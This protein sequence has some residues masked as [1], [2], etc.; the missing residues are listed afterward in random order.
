MSTVYK[1]PIV[2]VSDLDIE[3]VQ[4]DSALS[5]T[6]MSQRKMKE[7]LEEKILW[8]INAGVYHTGTVMVKKKS[9]PDVRTNGMKVAKARRL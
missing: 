1:F 7:Q 8:T 9:E 3:S 5:Q 2:C 6:A 4:L